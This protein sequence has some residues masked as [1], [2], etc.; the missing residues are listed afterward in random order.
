MKMNPEKDVS[1][2]RAKEILDSYLHSQTREAYKAIEDTN[3]LKSIVKSQLTFDENVL[4]LMDKPYTVV[5]YNDFTPVFWS[6]NK[7]IPQ[8]IKRLFQHDF[9]FSKL[10]NG[11]YLVLK[12]T[13]SDNY[14]ALALIPVF[15]TYPIQNKYL[16][17]GFSFSKE[18]C[19]YEISDNPEDIKIELP[20]GETEFFIRHINDVSTHVQW[21]TI[22]FLFIITGLFISFFFSLNLVAQLIKTNKLIGLL[23]ATFLSLISIY[24]LTILK[25]DAPI[26]DV[27]LYSS[28][29]FGNNLAMALFYCSILLWWL[30]ILYPYLYKPFQI[31]KSVAGYF[32]SFL[33]LAFHTLTL[34]FVLFALEDLINHSTVSFKFYNF[35]SLDIYSFISL[36]IYSLLFINLFLISRILYSW[37]KAFH[38][39]YLTM[40]QL[41]FLVV[42]TIFISPTSS[43]ETGNIIIL[44][45]FYLLFMQFEEK[46]NQI[47]MKSTKY[48]I[49]ISIFGIISSN[50]ILTN[51]ESRDIAAKKK[52]ITK[53]LYDRNYGEEFKFVEIG[54][55]IQSDNFIKS[56]FSNPYLF[57][58]SLKERLEKSHFNSFTQLYDIATYAFNPM[59]NTL[60][61]PE[62]RSFEELDNIFTNN[63]STTES[64]FFRFVSD[65][66]SKQSYLGKFTIISGGQILGY[67]FVEV[68]PKVYNSSS[69]SPELLVESKQPDN[70]FTEITYAIYKNDKLTSSN[71][72]YEYTKKLIFDSGVENQYIYYKDKDYFHFLYRS[73]DNTVAIITEKLTTSIQNLSIFSYTFC[74]YLIIISLAFWIKNSFFDVIV[75]DDEKINNSLQ[76]SIQ[77]SIVSLTLLFLLIVGVVTIIYFEQQYDNYHNQR[78]MRK[79][80]TLMKNIDVIAPEETKTNLD[81]FNVFI[82]KN[83]I[84]L[85]ETHTLDINVYDQK[86]KLSYSTQPDIFNKK[87]I[88]EYISPLAYT[89][90]LFKE[91]QRSVISEKIDQLNYLSAYIPFGEISENAL[92]F[93]H[94]PYYGKEQNIRS[95]ISYFIVALINVYV[96][97]ILFATF[98]AT[99]VARSITTPLS[100]IQENIKNLQLGKKNITIDWHKNDEIGVLIREYNRMVEEL[101]KSANL[102][103]KSERES[104]WREMAKQVAHEIKNPLTPMK[105]SIQHLQRAIKENRDNVD[106]LTLKVTDKLIEQIDNLSH[107]ATEFSSFAKMPQAQNEK[108][109]LTKIIRSTAHL[110]Q[111]YPQVDISMNIPAEECFI[112][113]DK[114][115]IMRVFNNIF[116]NAVQAIP[117]GQ[118]GEI[119]VDLKEKEEVFLIEISDNGKGIPKEMRKKVFEPNFTTKSSGTGLG[120]AI[121]R[122]IIEKANGRIWFESEEGVGTKFFILLPKSN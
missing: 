61:G 72:D 1:S 50:V 64:S 16:K 18:L 69:I 89:D 112:F 20:D 17:K 78:L 34:F 97:L 49:L 114:N 105:L 30:L 75:K 5:V 8:N 120:L 102:L 82:E 68:I 96:I 29:H 52:L 119:T 47:R 70:P 51:L 95:D 4:N 3:R 88:S 22:N 15:Y 11:Y 10:D 37:L 35:F 26:F 98:V 41:V 121:S 117:E 109:E 79:V 86:G 77:I 38:W 6:S 74:F 43:L 62:R 83:L 59:K 113:A 107:I 66:K 111:D 87:L 91:K 9:N 99:F 7:I 60:T 28:P 57:A 101:E 116:T 76:Q 81:S 80:N 85:A 12:N 24:I 33:V 92:A 58:I 23:T 73:S 46:L 44:F 71:G 63:S 45:F 2:E 122:N 31:P 13:F 32:A 40:I 100:V 93:F 55:N 94:F 14:T 106:E 53:L 90:I 118:K 103:A 115:Q 42:V 36:F 19:K 56:H 67:L 65:N 110:F 39:V 25:V 48:L 27:S 84:Q 108:I 21:S 54:M 104:A